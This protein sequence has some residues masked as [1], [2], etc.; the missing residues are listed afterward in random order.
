LNGQLTLRQQ[1]VYDFVREKIVARGYG[2]TVR[3]I[4]EALN[5]RSPNGVMCHLKALERKGVLQRMANKSRAIEL[6][7]VI[8]RDAQTALPISGRLLGDICSFSL[9]S[10]EAINFGDFLGPERF[11]LTV[12]GDKLR[13]VHIHSGDTLLVQRQATATAGQMVLV[14]LAFEGTRLFYWM[15]EQLRIR[16]QPVDKSQPIQFFDRAE[17]VGVVAGMIRRFQ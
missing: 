6:S 2:P 17:I 11:A 7:E 14:K 16:L 13:D 5:I 12:V 15:P 1:E 3:E 4:G 8:N 10:T 9:D